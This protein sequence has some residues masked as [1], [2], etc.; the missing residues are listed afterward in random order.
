[1][2]PFPTNKPFSFR[3]ELADASASKES[4]SLVFAAENE[5]AW[6][7]WISSFRG[8]LSVAE[9][10]STSDDPGDRGDVGG[11]NGD[12]VNSS[13][14]L[15]AQ[16]SGDTAEASQPPPASSSD[17]STSPPGMLS[18]NDDKWSSMMLMVSA[19]VSPRSAGRNRRPS[20]LQT[21]GRKASVGGT[22]GGG[23]GSSG[24]STQQTGSGAESGAT[25]SDYTKFG[26][27]FV[28]NSIQG[29]LSDATKIWSLR[30][31]TANESNGVITTFED[32]QG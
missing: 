9:A 13:N 19:L 3:L 11:G 12:A 17:D 31:I 20:L 5:A 15:D 4:D 30:Y 10:S 14:N 7:D 29:A 22:S 24:G 6:D 2:Y 23:G 18:T 25:S 32:K 8:L 27:L 16:A 1:M 26:Y 21:P 28:C